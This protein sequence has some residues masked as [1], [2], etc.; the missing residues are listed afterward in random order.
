MDS[1]KKRKKSYRLRDITEAC[2]RQ[3]DAKKVKPSESI[4][5]EKSNALNKKIQQS[6]C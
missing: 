4:V 6:D 5:N 3:K 1:Q 2:F